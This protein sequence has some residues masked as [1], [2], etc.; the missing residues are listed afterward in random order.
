M[1]RPN[2]CSV[3]GEPL[4]ECTLNARHRNGNVKNGRGHCPL[5][6]IVATPP[7]QRRRP[8]EVDRG[9]AGSPVFILPTFAGGFRITLDLNLSTLPRKILFIF[10]PPADALLFSP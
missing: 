9:A 5:L 4:A 10:L 2:L 8:A 7:V 1:A 3:S 6:L